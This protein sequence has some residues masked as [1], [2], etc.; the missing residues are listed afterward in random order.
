MYL[1]RPFLSTYSIAFYNSYNIAFKNQFKTPTRR[2]L[3]SKLLHI[4]N[5]VCQEEWN[6]EIKERKNCFPHESLAHIKCM[7]TIQRRPN[8]QQQC[9][10]AV[11]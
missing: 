1:I 3:S 11:Q 4:L 8:S 7:S 5:R 10:T 9:S 6:K 2:P